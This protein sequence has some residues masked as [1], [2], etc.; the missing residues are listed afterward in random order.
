MHRINDAALPDRLGAGDATVAI[1]NWPQDREL[2]AD[3]A[4]KGTPKL[5][6]VAAEANPPDDWD[7]L[8]DWIRLPAGYDDIRMRAA[9]LQRRAQRRPHPSIDDF[10]V[11]WRGDSW[12]ALSPVEARLLSPLLA[13]PGRVMSRRN[14]VGAA[15]PDGIAS[16]RVVDSYVKRLRHRIPPLGLAIHTVRQRG[17]FLAVDS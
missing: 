9:V 3:L 17:Y 10:G 12:V 5:L 6:L 13:S 8:T 14:L 11:V 15:W 4:R 16:E 1:V 7:R 2:V